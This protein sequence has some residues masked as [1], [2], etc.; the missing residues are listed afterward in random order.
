MVGTDRRCDL[1]CGRPHF[2]RGWCKLHY[3]R[4]LRNGDPRGSERQILGQAGQRRCPRCLVIR[5]HREFN[6]KLT[7]WQA[8][9]KHCQSVANR[10]RYDADPETFREAARRNHYAS[11]EQQLARARRWRRDHPQQSAY[12]SRLRAVREAG[13]PGS[14]TYEQLAARVTYFGGRCAYCSGPYEVIDHVK[15][16]A[17][18]GSQFASNLRPACSACNRSKHAQWPLEPRWR[19]P[20]IRLRG[21]LP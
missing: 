15:P 5:P 6:P 4:W 3:D 17:A 12:Q 1:G 14:H 16:L 11:R 20:P 9:C 7:G 10:L 13:A 8:A 2:A 18:E 21:R 19:C